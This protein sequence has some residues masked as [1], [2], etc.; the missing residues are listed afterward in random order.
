MKIDRLLSIVLL[1]LKKN[2]VTAS[3]LASYF[4]TS[5]R[6]IYRDID[7]LSMSGVP[8]VAEQGS[9][10]GY[11]L[12]E[13]FTI[14]K[15]FFKPEEMLALIAGLKGMENVFGDNNITTAID[16]VSTL[17][18]KDKKHEPIEIDFFG[19]GESAAIK[20]SI[21]LIYSAIAEKKIISF[22]YSNLKNETLNR[23]VEPYKIFFRSSNW[24]LMAYCLKRKDY[25]FFKVTRIRD[26]ILKTDSYIPRDPSERD[27]NS[28]LRIT[29]DR[30]PEEVEF[31]VDSSL[32][33]RAIE[34][35]GNDFIEEYEDGS[36]KI[37]VLYPVDEW[38]YSYLLGY[39]SSIT[40]LKPA[41]LREELVKRAEIFLTKNCNLT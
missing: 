32:A 6:T 9:G 18:P 10:G 19:W 14:E 1:M 40:I 23:A 22:T 29:E 21:K 39:G 25:R 3:E 4:E 37:N 2:K 31:I 34:Y 15:Q 30:V 24:Y 20:D 41:T 12:M 16:K 35:F 33:S 27:E 11:S 26:L 8:I 13:G 28:I 17:T 7:T 38:V 36:V 5:V